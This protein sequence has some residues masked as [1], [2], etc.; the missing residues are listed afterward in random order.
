MTSV[1]VSSVNHVDL[2][3]YEFRCHDNIAG[4]VVLCLLIKNM[5]HDMQ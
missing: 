1:L 3:T 2:Y 5:L 4:F